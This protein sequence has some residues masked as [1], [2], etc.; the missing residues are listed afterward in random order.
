MEDILK[1]GYFTNDEF[2]NIWSKAMQEP[3]ET[4]PKGTLRSFRWKDII[5]LIIN[6]NRTK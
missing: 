6:I 3:S 5:E 1:R 2:E 4:E